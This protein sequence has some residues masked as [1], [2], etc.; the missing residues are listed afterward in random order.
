[1]AAPFGGWGALL[2]LVRKLLAES[3]MIVNHVE[4]NGREDY[5]L[6]CYYEPWKVEKTTYVKEYGTPV[7]CE[8]IC[9]F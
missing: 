8:C 6:Y 1:M 3:L 5:N 9:P 7:E 4:T 2:Q